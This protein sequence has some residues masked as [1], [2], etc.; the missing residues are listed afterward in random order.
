M[1]RLS[2]VVNCDEI[3]VLEKGRVTERGTHQQL[4]EIPGSK[5]AGQ[6]TL[7]QL[8]LFECHDR[9]TNPFLLKPWKYFQMRK[10]SNIYGFQGCL[11]SDP[12]PGQMPVYAPKYI[13][14]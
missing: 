12:S 1:S 6:R 11:G 8:N 7:F 9:F 10:I 4:L 3:L 2:T 14:F 13:F 5:Y